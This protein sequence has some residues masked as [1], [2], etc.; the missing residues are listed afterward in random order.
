VG[1]CAARESDPVIYSH[2]ITAT[3]RVEISPSPWVRMEK[4]RRQMSAYVHTVNLTPLS[5]QPPPSRSSYT[6]THFR[7]SY[8]TPPLQQLGIRIIAE[9]S[10]PGRPPSGILLGG[11]SSRGWSL[12]PFPRAA[13]SFSN[14]CPKQKAEATSSIYATPQG[15]RILFDSP[16]GDG[17]P[18][19]AFLKQEK[20]R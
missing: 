19:D 18:L 5:L 1:R 6:A 4:R 12:T 2:H 20:S 14:V 3:T 7:E 16:G 13:H 17:I 15:T 8:T 9:F 10:V 11:G